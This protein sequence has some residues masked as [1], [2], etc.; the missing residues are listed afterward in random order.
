V[1]RENSFFRG[2]ELPRLLVLLTVLLAGLVLFWQLARHRPAPEPPPVVVEEHPRPIEP[3]RSVAF[4][5]VTDRTPVALRD[6]AAYARLLER[7]RGRTPAELASES[8]RDVLMTHLWERPEHYRGVPIHLDGA[9]LRVLRYE[10]KLSK[11]GWLYEAW[12]N[13]PESGKFPYVCV[14]EDPPNGLPIG[15]NV[16]ERVVFNGYFLKIMKY[17]AADVSRGAPLLVG[18]IGWDPNPSPAPQLPRKWSRPPA[19]FI[20]LAVIFAITLIRSIA[21]FLPSRWIALLGRLMGRR[22]TLLVHRDEI[23]PAT[24][25]QW[26]KSTRQNGDAPVEEHWEGDEPFDAASS[27]P[28][29]AAD[30]DEGPGSSAASGAQ[31]PDE[32]QSMTSPLTGG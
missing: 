21:L 19:L 13:T 2:S 29:G 7:A 15:A 12:I 16:S 27:E 17:E 5:T 3:D 1:Q 32:A 10:S 23:D 14:F 20:V 25:D 24:L 9:A 11:T 31:P 30:H 4:E 8:R 6:S 28:E 26:V 18:R 22:S